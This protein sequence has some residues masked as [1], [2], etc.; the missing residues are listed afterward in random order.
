MNFIK[1]NFLRWKIKQAMQ[2]QKSIKRQTPNYDE[3]SSI[4]I[5][6]KT[7]NP[8]MLPAIQ[9][10]INQLAKDNKKINVLVYVPANEAVI[11]LGFQHYTF[12]EKEIDTWGNINLEVVETFMN[13]SFDFLYCISKNDEPIFQY[14]LAKS[15]AKCRIGKFDEGNASFYEMMIHLKT[16]DDIAIFA[17]QALHYTQSIIYN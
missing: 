2:A 6:L 7:D 17:Q 11:D 1:K 15:K 4:G 9:K 16:E 3:A 13:Q 8:L 10:L 12:T 5:L 14:I